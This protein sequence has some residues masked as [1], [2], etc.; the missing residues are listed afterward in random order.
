MTAP[1]APRPKLF[2]T[3]PPTW[4]TPLTLSSLLSGL[5]A[6]LVL[7]MAPRSAARDVVIAG[8][9]SWSLFVHALVGRIEGGPES[10]SVRLGLTS[11]GLAFAVVPALWIAGRHD[12]FLPL[13][14]GAVVY[15]FAG[16]VHIARGST[17]LPLAAAATMI[18]VVVALNA[19]IA[20]PG[21]EIVEAAV[22]V[23]SAAL[24]LVPLPFSRTD[25]L[26]I[27]LV[28]IV[29]SSLA[30]LVVVAAR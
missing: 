20:R 29:A 8:A 7:V 23:M 16:V 13:L 5:V 4:A 27:G 6:A 28:F 25:P 22:A 18:I 2:S 19:S 30:A 9:L 21:G 26:R 14:V 12:P 10:L 15:A 1:L 11:K 3:L 24:L 17:G